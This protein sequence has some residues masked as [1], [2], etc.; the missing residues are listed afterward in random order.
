MKTSDFDYDLPESLIAQDPAVP[1]DA[2]RLLVY[3]SK[4]DSVEHCHFY[5]LPRF[6]NNDDVLVLNKSKVIPA[7][8]LFRVNGSLREIFLLKQLSL[9]T[10][11]VLLK[12]ARNFKLGITVKVSEELECTVLEILSDGRRVL[13][14]NLLSGVDLNSVIHKLGSMPLP[15]YIKHSKAVFEDYQ[16]VFA[17]NEGS[18]AAP[19][20]GLHFTR[21]LLSKLKILGVDIEEVILHIGLGTFAPVVDEELSDHK[22]HFEEYEM[23]NDVSGKL[24]SAIDQKKRIIAVGTTSVRVLESSFD[25]AKSS[26]VPGVS[27]TNI[28]IYPGSY[29]WKVVD[30][31]ITNFHLPKS[32]L[33]MLVSSFLEAK[34]VKKPVEKIL[35]LY[36]MAVKE[37]YK[38][39]SFGD[40]MLII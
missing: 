29:E 5:D 14:F 23:P 31:L 13:S 10:Y 25:S 34:G 1:R 9:N 30:S 40:A 7:R 11:E 24:N 8:I 39:F 35:S 2:C 37:G 17:S 19:T 27:N 22:M 28:F 33:I 12:P 15:P 38:F 6:L 16:T 20:A 18:K 3:N 4:T 26:F 21:E 32:T 36:E